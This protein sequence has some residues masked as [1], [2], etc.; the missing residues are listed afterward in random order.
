M[1]AK[2]TRAATD[3]QQHMLK[4]GGF[5]P[6]HSKIRNSELFAIIWKLAAKSR[7]QRSH[8]EARKWNVYSLLASVIAGRPEWLFI[9]LKD[10]ARQCVMRL[11]GV[12]ETDL[13]TSPPC[14]PQ[15]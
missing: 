11:D 5:G 7:V 14:C 12:H 3:R 6:P 9:C 4:H 10:H 1:D 8:N 2:P 15:V 13:I